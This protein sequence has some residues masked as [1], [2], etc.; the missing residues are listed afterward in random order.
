MQTLIVTN[1]IEKLQ[2][3]WIH[4]VCFLL[5]KRTEQSCIHLV[6]LQFSNIVIAFKNICDKHKYEND[7]FDFN[8]QPFVGLRP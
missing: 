8:S 3:T 4:L 5:S 1:E 7:N 6:F 2:T